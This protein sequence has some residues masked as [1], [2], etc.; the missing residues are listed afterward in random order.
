M[1]SIVFTSAPL[2]VKWG[3]VF[4]EPVHLNFI[5]NLI[6]LTLEIGQF[7]DYLKITPN[8]PTLLGV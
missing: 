5:T 7:E 1:F 2:S 4:T 8:R 3:H 6:V